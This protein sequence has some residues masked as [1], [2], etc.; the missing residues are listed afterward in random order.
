MSVAWGIMYESNHFP[1]NAINWPF[2]YRLRISGGQT[3]S[4]DSFFI[5]F[6]TLF[7]TIL[8]NV[9]SFSFTY[10]YFALLITRKTITNWKSSKAYTHCESSLSPWSDTLRPHHPNVKINKKIQF[11]LPFC[12]PC[13][14][15]VCVFVGG[16]WMSELMLLVLLSELGIYHLG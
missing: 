10:L 16:S 4:R 8:L 12:N 3:F 13:Q 15:E 14:S 9:L 5:F 11:W 1:T 7:L 2:C 6:G